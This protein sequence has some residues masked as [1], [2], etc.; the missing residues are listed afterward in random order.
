MVCSWG[1]FG[2]NT[3]K[4]LFWKMKVWECKMKDEKVCESVKCK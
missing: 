2:N 3:G 4:K 1:R